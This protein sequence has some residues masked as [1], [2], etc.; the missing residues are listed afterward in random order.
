ML[1]RG[2]MW[3]LDLSGWIVNIEVCDDN[4]DGENVVI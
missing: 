1:I 2:L 3:E 4:E